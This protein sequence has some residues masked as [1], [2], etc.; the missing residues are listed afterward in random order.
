MEDIVE[1][2]GLNQSILY[3]TLGKKYRSRNVNQSYLCFENAIYHYRNEGKKDD[4]ADVFLMECQ[5][6]LDDLKNQP[7]FAVVKTAIVILSFNNFEI[8]KRCVESI[9]QNI[10]KDV[11]ELIVVD[12]ASTD[13]VQDWLR[14]QEDI[15]LIANKENM[16]FPYGCNQG[17]A[18]AGRLS[19][20]LLLNNDTIVP[21]NAIFWLR[22]GLYENEKIAASGSVSNHAVNYQQVMK[23]YESVEQWIEFANSNNVPMKQPYERKS[24][25][26]GFAMLIKRSALED[27]MYRE[28]KPYHS[29]FREILDHRFSPGNFEDNDMGIRLLSAGYQLLLVKNSFIYHYGGKAFEQIQQQYLQLMLKNKEKM[30][31]KYGID[32]TPFFNLETALVDLVKPQKDNFS[33]LEIGCGLGIILARIESMYAGVSVL[34]LEKNEYL[35]KLAANVTNVKNQDF[36]MEYENGKSQ[37]DYVIFDESLYRKQAKEMLLKARYCLNE[38][39]KIL[40]A[41]SNAQCIKNKWQENENSFCLDELIELCMICK[42]EI[43]VLNYRYAD[44][45]DSEEQQIL[46]ICKKEDNSR[47][48]LYR[49]G[50]FV[51]EI[52]K[53]ID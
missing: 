32:L 5:R 12:N 13:G 2:R 22:M 24:W 21:E 1:E 19:D 38:K 23:Q 53:C 4:P 44:L 46:Y 9:R 6:E 35:A 16:G 50:K 42:L 37:Y 31:E 52:M 14:H 45:S 11:Y 26:M 25:L 39:G 28:H 10:L 43:K 34:G 17:I 18:A 27:V 47:Q 20:I 41:F 51:L 36:L 7:Q 29:N 30:A 8:T 15:C 40:I 49:I 3:Q 33:V 48:T